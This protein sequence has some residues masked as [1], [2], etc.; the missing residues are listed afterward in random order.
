MNDTVNHPSHYTDCFPPI[1]IECIDFTKDMSFLRGNAFKYVW[2]A[3]NK[4]NAVEDLKKALWYLTYEM[5]P[6][7]NEPVENIDFWNTVY[8]KWIDCCLREF[9]ER[10]IEI[11]RYIASGAL[12]AAISEIKAWIK[13]IETAEMLEND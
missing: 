6:D 12:C 5:F 4:N 7:L 9:D 3:G 8:N 11:L 10:K 2:R 1:Q 13:D